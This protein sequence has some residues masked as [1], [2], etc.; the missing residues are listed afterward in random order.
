MTVLEQDT[1]LTG[2]RGTP[3]AWSPASNGHNWTVIRGNQT[4]SFAS[5]ELTLTYTS[6]NAT[7]IIYLGSSSVAAQDITVNSTG[8]ANNDIIGISGR[9]VDSTH[10]YQ[11]ELGNTLNT[12]ELR[13]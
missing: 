2:G 6:S 12:L 4:L 13:K 7:A 5:N 11:L 9:V 3:N 1:A 10:Y 8:S